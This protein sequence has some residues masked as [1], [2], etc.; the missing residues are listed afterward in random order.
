MYSI[1]KLHEQSFDWLTWRNGS[2]V[3]VLKIPHRTNL[4]IANKNIIRKYAI[5]YCESDNIP[6]KPKVGQYAVM[7]NTGEYY[8]WWTH[9]R[10]EEFEIIFARQ[11]AEPQADNCI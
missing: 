10:K 3:S 11:D 4:L 5:G 9:L 8:D 2:T 7:F 1:R 6:C